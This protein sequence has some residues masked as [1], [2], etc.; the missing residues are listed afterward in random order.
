MVKDFSY[1]NKM[2]L[3][4]IISDVTSDNLF[5]A[6]VDWL[7]D[8]YL[9]YQEWIGMLNIQK[10]ID[11][12]D[13]YHTKIL[14]K[15]NT[16]LETLE[17]IFQ[18]VYS[19]DRNYASNNEPHIDACANFNQLLIKLNDA[20]SMSKGDFSPNKVDAVLSETFTDYSVFFSAYNVY[21][22]ELEAFLMYLRISGVPEED[23]ISIEYKI[24]NMDEPYRTIYL[25]SMIDYSVG[26]LSGD[27][28]YTNSN[29]TI[30]LNIESES[31]N[32]RGEYTTFFHESGHA[33]DYNYNDDGTFY[34]LTYTNENGQ[35]LMD[36]IYN[37]VSNDVKNAITRETSNPEEINKLHD[38]IMNP[39]SRN[40]IELSKREKKLL[41]DVQKYY[42]G[43]T[44]KWTG[45][46]VNGVLD[47]YDN[48]AASDVYGGMTNNF[49]YG[50]YTHP[51]GDG[52]W[53][54]EN[55]QATNYQALELWAEYYSAC[56]TGDEAALRSIEERF[57]EAKQFL[58]EMAR[59]M[60]E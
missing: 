37:D 35:T 43:Y 60:V 2:K 51:E 54:D 26:N 44:S 30:N 15:N 56:A 53:Y 49:I 57:P 5:E 28:F 27:G 4:E 6:A 45:Q 13:E 3:R 12:I 59:S 11:N 41:E 17:R 55:G 22:D 16:T 39:G 32:K 9:D 8:R 14:D 20:I 21:E 19:I 46:N 25:Q 10:Y 48:E 40:S 36:V 23:V 58:D 29:N 34:S 18:E 47:G 33:I 50:Y 24:R 52:Y 7:G 31:E 38:Y 42:N 1:Q